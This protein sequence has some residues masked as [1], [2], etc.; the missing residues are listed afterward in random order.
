MAHGIKIMAPDTQRWEWLTVIDYNVHRGSDG[1]RCHGAEA[2]ERGEC[3]AC[4]RVKPYPTGNA[5]AEAGTENAL[6]FADAKSALE[7]GRRS[8]TVTPLRPDGKPNRPLTVFTWSVEEIPDD[9]P[10]DEVGALL[11]D[12]E[13][14]AMLDV[15]TE[16][17]G[18]EVVHTFANPSEGVLIGA[19]R[20]LDGVR[21]LIEREGAQ[22]SGPGAQALH[23]GLVIVSDD[24]PSLF[25]ATKKVSVDEDPAPEG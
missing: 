8:S 22:L 13:A 11:S 24:A 1:Q 18:T 7:A 3:V 15:F 23:H 10:A 5:D 19:D 17:D 9:V 21:A 16:E 14:I 6:R 2:N 25:L 4:G 20:T 12:E